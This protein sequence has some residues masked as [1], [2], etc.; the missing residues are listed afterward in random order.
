MLLPG[1]VQAAYR[2]SSD[3]GMNRLDFI[4]N[5]RRAE[6]ENQPSEAQKKLAA[7]T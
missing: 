2:G 1:A 6:R 5:Q 4:E 7:E 3:A